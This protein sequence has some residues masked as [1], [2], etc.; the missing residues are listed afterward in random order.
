[1]RWATTTTS[2]TITTT[3]TSKAR[4]PP[5]L[6][7]DTIITMSSSNN[8][9]SS[10]NISN[11]S[12]TTKWYKRQ[13]AWTTPWPTPTTPLP[14]SPPAWPWSRRPRRRPLP[15]KTGTPGRVAPTATRTF[16]RCLWSG[17]SRT[18]TSGARTPTSSALSAG[19]S[20]LVKT[21]CTATSIGCTATRKTWCQ[22]FSFRSEPPIPGAGLRTGAGPRA[23]AS[24]TRTS[25][26]SKTP[27]TPSWTSRTTL[28]T[29]RIESGNK[30]FF[31]SNNAKRLF[32]N[33]TTQKTFCSLIRNSLHSPMML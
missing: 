13:T 28:Q 33:R 19:N 22:K 32:S 14:P 10:N 5:S 4:P 1:M 9:N 15:R 29:I 27:V 8:N 16:T 23:A 18:C 26:T 6:P 12:F 2:R 3:I 21:R 17:T 31:E 24:T 11:S 7:Q 20:T 25:I 30:T